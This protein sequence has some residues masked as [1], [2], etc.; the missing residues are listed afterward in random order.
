MGFWPQYTW[1]LTAR[2]DGVSILSTTTS[3]RDF[4]AAANVYWIRLDKPTQKRVALS[5]LQYCRRTLP[6]FARIKISFQGH[7]HFTFEQVEKSDPIG[8]TAWGV[9]LQPLV[10]W[11]TGSNPAGKWIRV[12][13]EC[14]VLFSGRNPCDGPISHPENPYRLFVFFSVIRSQIS[15]YTY[16][17]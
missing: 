7:Q 2:A 8:R 1:N 4:F 15:L 9:S 16:R 12:C 3:T 17:K 6:N 10:C 11:Y 5:K 13:C 14:G